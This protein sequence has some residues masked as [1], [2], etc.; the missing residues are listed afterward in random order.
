MIREGKEKK[1]KKKKKKWKEK[2]KEEVWKQ[3]KKKSQSGQKTIHKIFKMFLIENISSI[4][5]I[6]MW[7]ISKVSELSWG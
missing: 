4:T 7:A 1:K 5:K 2:K 3:K 6:L